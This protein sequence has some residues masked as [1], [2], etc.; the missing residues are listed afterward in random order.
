MTRM[1]NRIN[2]PMLAVAVGGFNGGLV[3]LLVNL[4][5]HAIGEQYALKLIEFQY[6]DHLLEAA[7]R[8]PF[9]LFIVLL[10]PTLAY[11]PRCSVQNPS[12]DFGVLGQLKTV[13]RK[14]MVVLHNGC[15]GY[16][17]EAIK[18][19]GADAVFEMPFDPQVFLITLSNC[20]RVEN[21][22]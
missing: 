6:A 9:D 22:S 3:D 1:R 4:S 8:N 11:S 12:S 15:A 16:S 18:Q 13:Y 20:L 21:L 5:Q 17:A 14:P 7:H 10:N 19:A 2:K